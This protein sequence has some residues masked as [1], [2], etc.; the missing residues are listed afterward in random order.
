MAESREVT[1]LLNAW[2]EGDQ[3]ALDQLV[4]LVYAELHRLARRQMRA[5]HH[6]DLLQATALIHEAYVR[7]VKVRGVRWQN[8]AHFFAMSAKLM[9]RVLVDAARKR[10]AGKRGVDAPRIALDDEHVPAADADATIVALDEALESLARIDARKSQVIELR[11]FGGLTV[12]QAAAVLG[13]ST[14]TV[15]REWEVAKLWL[16]R[17]LGRHQPPRSRVGA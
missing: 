2:C 4:P 11:H 3:A 17:E 15:E 6:G 1:A 16:G 14:R 5:E 9:R 13:V 8:R 7:L 10:T 12:R